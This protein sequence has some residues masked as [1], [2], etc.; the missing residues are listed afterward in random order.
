MDA[1]A[2]QFKPLIGTEFMPSAPH[3]QGN[4]ELTTGNQ[5]GGETDPQEVVQGLPG[6]NKEADFLPKGKYYGVQD[7]DTR[8]Q[9]Q[10]FKLTNLIGEQ[11]FGDLDFSLFKRH[12]ALLHHHSTIN[13]LKRNKSISMFFSLKTPEE[14]HSLLQLSRQKAAAL[15]KK[16][17]QDEKD[18]I[19]RR[20][21]ILEET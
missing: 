13:M 17:H 16:H 21:L 3:L 15:Q 8:K 20:Q 2:D 18:A 11:A 12:N 5:R 6:N 14:Q 19:A 1:F 7:E 10:H 4:A 9:L